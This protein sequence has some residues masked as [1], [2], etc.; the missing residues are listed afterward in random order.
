MIVPMKKAKL[1]FMEESKESVLKTLQTYGVFMLDSKHQKQ[2]SV[3]TDLIDTQKAI[4][5]VEKYL[6]KKSFGS[7]E[8]I[9]IDEFEVIDP[10]TV[11]LVQEILAKSYELKDL[12]TKLQD[13]KHQIEQIYPYQSL[14]V[15]TSRLNHLKYLT[16][17]VGKIPTEKKESLL[18]HI[19][20][21]DAYYDELGEQSGFSYFSMVVLNEDKDKLLEVINQV[22]FSVDRLDSFEKENASVVESLQKELIH[23]ADEIHMIDTYF[24]EQI[25][26]LSR[27]KLLYDQ[28]LAR[29]QRS[30]IDFQSTKNTIYVEG[31]MRSDQVRDLEKILTEQQIDFELETRD[32][33]ED[34]MPP[35]SL[36][37]N[38][39]VKPFESI[40]N[41]FSIPNPKEIDPNPIMSIWY[42][43]IF[44]IMVGD[45]GYGLLMVLL[46]GAARK[47]GKLKGGLKDLVTVFLYSG[48]TSIAAGAVFGSFL[49]FDAPWPKL[50]D[51]IKDPLPMLI[52]S[53][54][55]GIVHILCGLVLKL[56]LAIRRKD[57][58]G[59]LADSVSWI[60]ILTGLS[61]Y[62]ITLALPMT[63]TVKSVI[64]YTALVL[65]GL[66]VLLIIL[67]N[68]RE[69]PTFMGKAVSAFTGLYNST[70]YLSDILS[71]SRILAL[72]LS[73]GVIAMTFNILGEMV[74]N[75]IPVIGIILGLLV[76][77]VGHVFNF[78]MGLLSAYVHAGRLQYLEFY[79]K[80][81]EG[82]GY[83]YEPLQLQLKYVY[84]VNLKKDN[85]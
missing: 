14:S 8:T 79:G 16:G 6:K 38:A 58:L 44:G 52:I 71:Y 19:Q 60:S 74:F 82:G 36:K 37:N 55:L 9:S 5:Q 4:E 25:N 27:L 39:F 47:F 77:I 2:A 17:L 28:L 18:G 65:I 84:K 41:Q 75:S 83:L 80:F 64:T 51:P 69:K 57:I 12:E 30:D 29:D 46:F 33:L 81:F 7:N 11:E 13:T 68:G 31:W 23:L 66:G 34:E 21:L 62:A 85:N 26:Q 48:I 73:S 40:T 35:T 63:D 15:P 56:I 22:G 20:S 10:K 78:V 24:T 54:A 59:A 53:I 3:S 72:A 76:Y 70:A 42:W 32:P 61:L 1:I 43:I 67:L 49:G 50:I 45:M